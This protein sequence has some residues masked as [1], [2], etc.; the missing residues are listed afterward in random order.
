MLIDR[1]GRPMED[2]RITLTHVCNFSCFFCHMEGEELL[3][4]DLTANEIRL[5]ASVAKEIGIESVK[6]TGGEPTVRKDILEIVG[7]VSDFGFKDI[8]LTTNGFMLTKLAIKLRDAGLQRINISLHSLNR[9]RF[10]KITG[11]DGLNR[12]LEGINSAKGAGFKQI[13]LNFVVTKENFDE[14]HNII[15]FAEENGMNLHL[16]ELHPVGLG[17]ES[18]SSHEELTSVERSLQ[19]VARKVEV[20]KKHFRPVYILPSGIKVEIVKPYANPL[21]CAGCNRI[22]LTADGKLKTCLYRNDLIVDILE[23]VRGDYSPDEKKRLI[24]K[25]FKIANFIRE[26]N[27]KWRYSYDLPFRDIVNA[28]H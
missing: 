28:K 22:R 7:Y 19:H 15:Q 4:N 20:R 11:V 13:K 16:I 3:P 1:Y 5:I 23:I 8:S 18:F 14:I 25:A 26:P 2:L 27:F 9:E 10:K 12:V 24:V 21:F 6:F 17:K